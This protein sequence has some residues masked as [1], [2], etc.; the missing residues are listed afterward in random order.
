MKKLLIIMMVLG[1]VVVM[2]PVVGN[3]AQTQNIWITVSVYAP[4]NIIVQNTI[5][6]QWYITNVNFGDITNRDTATIVSNAGS[7]AIDLGLAVVNLDADWVNSLT[8]AP[9]N[10]IYVLQGIFNNVGNSQATNSD[11]DVLDV[12]KTNTVYATV[13]NFGNPTWFTNGNNV[14]NNDRRQLW[15]K[16]TVP[17]SGHANPSQPTCQLVISGQL[18]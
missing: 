3:S 12:I 9:G 5:T 16:F 6:T 10:D 15:L 14:A 2:M 17:T 7:A 13:T 11:Y 8:T 4:V 18:H 1:L